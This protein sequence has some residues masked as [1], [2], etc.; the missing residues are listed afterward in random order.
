MSMFVE[1]IIDYTRNLSWCGDCA[2]EKPID[3]GEQELL[4]VSI[5]NYSIQ[6]SRWGNR[7]FGTEP[8]K[9]FMWSDDESFQSQLYQESDT[10][11]ERVLRINGIPDHDSE[12]CSENFIGQLTSSKYLSDRFSKTV[13]N[14]FASTLIQDIN[15]AFSTVFLKNSPPKEGYE[16]IL[17]NKQ[18]A[19]TENI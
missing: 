18:L 3:E 13:D 4:Q 12:N 7:F 9:P 16:E 11:T 5:T 17:E 15:K 1:M 19:N 2:E 6:S 10:P 14:L 8:Q